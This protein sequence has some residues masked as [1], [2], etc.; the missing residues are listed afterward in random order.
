MNTD[1][2][3]DARD[4]LLGVALLLLILTAA[5]AAHHFISMGL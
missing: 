2:E 3:P 4:L 1:E 5:V